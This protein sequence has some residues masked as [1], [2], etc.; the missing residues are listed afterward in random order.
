MVMTVENAW[1]SLIIQAQTNSLHNNN[2]SLY[3]F[4]FKNVHIF[5][6]FVRHPLCF[7][8]IF[9]L[10]PIVFISVNDGQNIIVLV[11]IRYRY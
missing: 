8:I 9:V 10:K 3:L 2:H 5:I 6:S 7:Y 1:E 11:I 4:F